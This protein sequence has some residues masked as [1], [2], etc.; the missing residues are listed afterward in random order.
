MRIRRTAF[1]VALVLPLVHIAPAADKNYDK[2]AQCVAK[3]GA[4]MYG[5]W[6]C[7]HCKDQKEM[8]GDSFTYINYV[9]CADLLDRRKQTQACQDKNIQK[10]PTWIFNETVKIA[11][12]KDNGATAATTTSGSTNGTNT[13]AGGKN[14]K[15]A[16][17]K[18]TAS[19]KAIVDALTKAGGRMPLAD[20]QKVSAGK[21]TLPTLE[22]RAIVEIKEETKEAERIVKVFSFEELSEKTGCELPKPRAASQPKPEAPSPNK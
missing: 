3:K 2:F 7:P 4:V 14:S 15:A 1:F 20:L 22:K 8:F 5:A 21:T 19:Q 16:S 11:V 18:L 10:Y 17:P 9:E 12:L 6:W 13:V